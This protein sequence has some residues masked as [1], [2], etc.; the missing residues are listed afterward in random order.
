LF[1]CTTFQRPLTFPS[2]V[3]LISVPIGSEKK[4]ISLSKTKPNLTP[5]ETSKIFIFPFLKTFYFV[6][7]TDGKTFF[8][9]LGSFFGLVDHR[10]FDLRALRMEERVGRI[11]TQG[12]DSSKSKKEMKTG[13]EE[14][15]LCLTRTLMIIINQGTERKV[16][17]MKNVSSKSC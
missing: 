5:I 13:K 10:R 6:L 1:N 16:N 8:R 9:N 14:E 17:G 3:L 2:R 11:P 7:F 15:K 4:N 12:N